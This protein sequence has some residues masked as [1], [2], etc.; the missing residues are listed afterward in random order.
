MELKLDDLFESHFTAYFDV[1]NTQDLYTEINGIFTDYD[2][3]IVTQAVNIVKASIVTGT[4][5]TECHDKIFDDLHVHF[6][7]DDDIDKFIISLTLKVL[8]SQESSSIEDLM[9]KPRNIEEE[10]AAKYFRVPAD[11]VTDK[12]ITDVIEAS[13]N[14][15]KDSYSV[16]DPVV[17]SWDEYFYNVCRQVARN[18]KCLSR[19]I[20]AVMVR[21][22]SIISTGY[23]GPP[24]GVPRCDRRWTL[25]PEF[26]EKYGK[27]AEGQ[28][29]EGRCPRYVI[30]FKSGEGLEICPAGH[31]ERNALI[32]AAR[33]GIATKGASLYM[34]CG[35]PCSP[36]MVE[37][38]NAGIKEIV[39]TSLKIYDETSKY[40]LTQ[41]KLGVRLF[42]FVK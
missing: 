17:E 1:S 22:K 28:D 23:N 30:G 42:D 29:V 18:S 35:I 4:S 37:I 10:V 36:C 24:R 40:L 14:F 26:I 32:N 5:Y 2:P 33:Y 15:T 27:F 12:M 8:I 41:S 3:N 39:V 19:R 20:G 25:D 21:D 7:I 34:S 6:P 11:K 31:A 16:T 9:S 38:I 13:E